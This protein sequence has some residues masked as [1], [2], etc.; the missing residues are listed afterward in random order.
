[1]SQLRNSSTFFEEAPQGE[2]LGFI[3]IHILGVGQL[4]QPLFLI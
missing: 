4:G 1:M 2:H 3:V